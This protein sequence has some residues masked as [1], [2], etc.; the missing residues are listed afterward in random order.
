MYLSWPWS[1]EVVDGPYVRVDER[2]G[3]SDATIPAAVLPLAVAFIPSILRAGRGRRKSL[4][5]ARP[6]EVSVAV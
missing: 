4:L 5:L 2:F 1:A 3:W 6:S